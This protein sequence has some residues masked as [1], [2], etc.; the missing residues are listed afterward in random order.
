MSENPARSVTVERTRTGHFVAT[1]T[2]GGTI[3][4]GTGSDGE[5]TPVELLGRARRLYG[6]GRRPGHQ[7]YMPNPHPSPSR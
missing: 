2:R 5:F 4:F 7:L 1:N 3:D 6:G